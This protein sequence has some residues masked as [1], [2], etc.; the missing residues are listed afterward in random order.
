MH[1]Q[2]ASLFTRISRKKLFFRN[3]LAKIGLAKPL[4]GFNFS[5]TCP[6]G[7]ISEFSEDGMIGRADAREEI[8]T[9]LKDLNINHVYYIWDTITTN[10]RTL[11]RHMKIYPDSHYG[12]ALKNAKGLQKFFWRY[13][14]LGL[15]HDYYLYFEDENDCMAFQ[16]MR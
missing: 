5:A 14:G 3:L 2:E 12:A 10:L 15:G 9:I 16:L 11:D 7:I 4:Y 8:K 1:Q 13:G 6:K